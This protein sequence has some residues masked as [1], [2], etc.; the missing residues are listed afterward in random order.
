MVAQGQKWI[1]QQ[2]W[3]LNLQKKS[4]IFPELNFW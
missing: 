2:I 4:E 3:L 1:Y